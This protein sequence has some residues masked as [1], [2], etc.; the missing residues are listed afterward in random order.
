[1]SLSV[2]VVIRTDPRKSHRAAEALRI[3][4]GLGAGEN[5]VTVVLLGKAPALLS[6]GEDDL[7]DSELLAK[8]LPV[9]KELKVPFVVPSGALTAF[10]PAPGFLTR[11][12]SSVEI[13]RLIKQSDRVLVF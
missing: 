7:V 9:L 8:H 1:M 2:T 12:A 13:A 4:L 6:E 5:P 3:A 10:G 11:E